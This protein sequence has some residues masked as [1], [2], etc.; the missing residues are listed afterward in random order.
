MR[1]FCKD[2][3]EKWYENPLFSEQDINKL[4][5]VIVVKI[6]DSKNE[7]LD[8]RKVWCPIH[9]NYEKIKEYHNDGVISQVGCSIK[10]LI[11]YTFDQFGN[12]DDW[13]FS[14]NNRDSDFR[15]TVKDNN[16]YVDSISIFFKR[17][18]INEEF[19]QVPIITSF[20]TTKHDNIKDADYDIAKYF[21]SDIV[22]PK[23]EEHKDYNKINIERIEKEKLLYTATR[24][25]G[26]LHKEWECCINRYNFRQVHSYDFYK[27]IEIFLNGVRFNEKEKD[28]ATIFIVERNKE[29][30]MTIL[31]EK[32]KSI[33]SLRCTSFYDKLLS[34]KMD[35][36]VSIWV[37][38]NKLK[39]RYSEVERKYSYLL[40]QPFKITKIEESIYDNI[41]LIDML[42][43]KDIQPGYYLNLSWK[44][45]QVGFIKLRFIR[46][47][48]NELD[49][50]KNKYPSIEKLVNAVDTN[51]EAQFAMYLI[52]AN[53]IFVAWRDYVKMNRWL[54]KAYN[55]GWKEPKLDIKIW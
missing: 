44:Y 25:L 37:K 4:S 30:L 51:V 39:Q 26:I 50:L 33:K 8:I 10:G 12:I 43:I 22:P 15:I 47:D 41:P 9:Q 14:R 38:H 49:I 17:R 13:P 40:E 2:K 5:F 20:K 7:E 3:N 1:I 28:T 18:K 27:Y 45:L 24:D 16:Y 31:I 19:I 11:V 21:I 54:E 36:L 34:I 52:Y 55:N 35:V 48:E 42:K 46:G 53:C 6:Y 23:E 32:D 29:L